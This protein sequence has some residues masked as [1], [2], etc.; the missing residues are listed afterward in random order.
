MRS[1]GD[2]HETPDA[3]QTTMIAC[4]QETIRRAQLGDAR[5]WEILVRENINWIFR[6]CRRWTYS[7]CRSEDLT[8]DVFVKVFQNLHMYKSESGEFRKW[9]GRITHNLLVD[10]YRG[11][12]KDRRTFS[13]DHPS[14]QMKGILSSIASPECSPEV[15]AEYR[16]QAAAL[17]A[18]VRRLDPEL[19]EALI[20]RHEHDLSYGEISDRLKLPEGTVKSRISRAKIELARLRRSRTSG[21]CGFN[22]G[23]PAMV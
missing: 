13:Y 19:R 3:K 18:M 4:D 2:A 20:L 8:Q 14:D 17:S 11:S 7:T 10:H 21:W 22:R 12:C 6:I 23:N 5:A 15:N 9:L 1:S 16:E